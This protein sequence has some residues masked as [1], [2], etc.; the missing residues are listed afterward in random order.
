[1]N[2][3]YIEQVKLG[4]VKQGQVHAF[5]EMLRNSSVERTSR[6]LSAPKTNFVERRVLTEAGLRQCVGRATV[7]LETIAVSMICLWFPDIHISDFV[8][9]SDRL[10][11]F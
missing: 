2:L 3:R 11:R 1:M 8:Q 9:K 7:L 6:V 5:S 4:W 10:R